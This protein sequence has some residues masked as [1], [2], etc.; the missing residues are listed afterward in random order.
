MPK[1]YS[2][3]FT[4]HSESEEELNA[5][6]G[7]VETLKSALEFILVTGLNA[8]I[9]K[10]TTAADDLYMCGEQANLALATYLSVDSIA[11]YTFTNPQNSESICFSEAGFLRSRIQMFKE[12]LESIV[13]KVNQN[14]G[15]P[16]S[17]V[18]FELQACSEMARKA[19]NFKLVDSP[20]TFGGPAIP[21]S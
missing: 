5:L 8:A 13:R 14:A 15:H 7:Q 2:G 9:V 11:N 19:L 12:T 16:P 10:P 20:S 17:A 18:Q 21:G 1:S 4:N 3:S 6:A